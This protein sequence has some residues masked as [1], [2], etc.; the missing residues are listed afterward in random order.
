MPAFDEETFGPLA[1]VTI[2]EDEQA[3]VALA[4]HSPYGLA[5]SIW[6]RDLD[7]AHALARHIDAGSVFI[8]TLVKSDPR[9]PFGGIKQS[10]FGR[11]LGRE[12]M[13]EFVNAKTIAG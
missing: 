4:N 8:N 1:C 13:R 7:K 2:A 3:A 9:L 10:G 5:A 6:S 12:G 11:E